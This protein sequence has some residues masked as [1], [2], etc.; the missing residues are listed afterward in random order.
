MRYQLIKRT[1]VR[2]NG[3][4]RIEVR[5]EGETNV[6][7]VADVLARGRVDPCEVS[8]DVLIRVDPDGLETRLR[9]TCTD[10]ELGEIQDAMYEL[11]G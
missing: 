6:T 10:E 9:L 5:H 8:R 11:M 4:N 2:N 1:T 3:A 7:R